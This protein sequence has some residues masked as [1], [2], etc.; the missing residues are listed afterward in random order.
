MLSTA[1]PYKFPAAVLEGLGEAP[2]EDEFDVM[3]RLH[4]LT[5]VP[6]PPH[7]ADLRQRQVRHRDVIDRQDMLAYVLRKAGEAEWNR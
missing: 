2:G 4:A 6:V 3:Q 1:S 7:L 5:G